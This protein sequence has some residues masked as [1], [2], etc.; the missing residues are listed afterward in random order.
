MMRHNR[1]IFSIPTVGHQNQGSS[2]PLL[3]QITFAKSYQLSDI[4][5]SLTKKTIHAA[6]NW[7]GGRL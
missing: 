3:N 5:G 1:T 4:S 6:R 7:R 2:Q